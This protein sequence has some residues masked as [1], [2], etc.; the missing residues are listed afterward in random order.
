M[1]AAQELRELPRAPVAH[2][3]D[4]TVMAPATPLRSDFAPHAHLVEI[5]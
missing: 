5:P 3:T 4:L 1:Q 2:P